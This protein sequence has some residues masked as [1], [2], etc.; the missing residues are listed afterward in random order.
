MC[1]GGVSSARARSIVEPAVKELRD[2]AE[3]GR[4]RLRE[5]HDPKEV[6]FEKASPRPVAWAVQCPM[7]GRSVDCSM[8]E[9]DDG[10]T[11]TSSDQMGDPFV[12]CSCE[13]VIEPTPVTVTDQH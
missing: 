4:T 11:W 10:A 2:A 13:T 12:T 5:P 9:G 1:A 3:W 8:N 6:V 7:C